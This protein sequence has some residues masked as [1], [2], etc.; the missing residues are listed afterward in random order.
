MHKPISKL[1]TK[2]RT[3]QGAG[4]RIKVA[5]TP[6]KEFGGSYPPEDK[7]RREITHLGIGDG[8]GVTQYFNKRPDGTSITRGTLEAW[9]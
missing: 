4:S 8:K 3:T 5:A 1:Q 2:E 7:I 6:A 9:K